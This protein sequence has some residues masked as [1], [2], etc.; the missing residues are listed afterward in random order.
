M[1]IDSSFMLFLILKNGTLAI[2]NFRFG[3]AFPQIIALI[4]SKVGVSLKAILLLYS[5][6]FVVFS[7]GIYSA[8]KY[9]IK[10][11]KI[12]LSILLFNVLMISAT[13]YWMH[14]EQIQGTAWLLLFFALQFNNPLKNKYPEINAALSYLLLFIVAFVHP[15]MIF[16]FS[17]IAIFLFISKIE[18]LGQPSKKELI[19]SSLF[20]GIVFI[21][22]LVFFKNYYD[23]GA[24]SN[25]K[26]FI[27][28]FPNYFTI[29]SNK[30]F[31]KYV[32]SDYYLVIILLFVNSI[33]YFKN[34]NWR[35]L[36]LL[37]FF[38]IAY[39][40]MVNVSYK[41]GADKFYIESHYLSLSLF[42]IISFVFDVFPLI[43]MRKGIL[44][45]L[46]LI[47]IRLTHIYISHIPVTKRL[48]WERQY[49]A[50]TANLPQKKIVT[51]NEY[52]PI[53]TL[54]M[55]W[56]T[57]Y[58]F[59]LLSTLEQNSTRSIVILENV[60]AL[61]WALKENKTFIT[62]WGNFKYEN[63]PS[64]YFIMKD[65]TSYIKIRE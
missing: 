18:Y 40:L 17:F 6:S 11:E 41:N 33:I 48:N 50:K 2:Q 44:I 26:N 23:A 56:S 55:T 7:L 54:L 13:F 47:I 3:A 57:P 5:I 10:N 21:I 39:L 35:K 19:S 42:V 32:I 4:S 9:L 14:S 29:Q 16:Q 45:L 24:I 20:F 22:K 59:W 37:D 63:L 30:N 60:D 64:K 52:V 36:L 34:R 65:S 28:L 46:A 38:F 53:D 8:V 1:F 25:V 12:A 61:D 31:L 49:L 62:N 15:I 27:D 51:G 58:E 43:E